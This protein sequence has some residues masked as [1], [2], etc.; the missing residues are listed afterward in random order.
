MNVIAREIEQRDNVQLTKIIKQ[1]IVEYGLPKEGTVYSDPTTNS[2]FELFCIEGSVYWVAEEDGELL[3]GCGI[4][5]TPGLPDKYAELVKFYL[6]PRSRGKGITW[7][8]R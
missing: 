6:K 8:R 2:L 3:G 5:P 7:R 4:Y 1:V